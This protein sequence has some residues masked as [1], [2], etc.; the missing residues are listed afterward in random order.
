MSIIP[1]WSEETQNGRKSQKPCEVGVVCRF[2]S[3]WFTLGVFWQGCSQNICS[4]VH[5][6]SLF[7]IFICPERVCWEHMPFSVWTEIHA[8][9]NVPLSSQTGS[10]T[11]NDI[12]LHVYSIIAF[13]WL[14]MQMPNGSQRFLPLQYC[15]PRHHIAPYLYMNIL[16]IFVWV[17]V[18]C[19]DL[20]AI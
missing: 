11:C 16:Y 15:R 10:K 12:F 18:S 17:S 13:S 5:Y 6:Y 9:I 3:S 7:F 19:D 8:A 4:F 1:G 2:H 14:F 20:N